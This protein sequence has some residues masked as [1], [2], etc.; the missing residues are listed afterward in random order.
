MERSSFTALQIIKGI[1]SRN[2]RLLIFNEH[3]L[4]KT[5]ATPFAFLE[6]WLIGKENAPERNF[7]MSSTRGSSTEKGRGFL[8]A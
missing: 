8:I 3:H 1:A 6:Q 4:A 5:C 7:M 2:Y